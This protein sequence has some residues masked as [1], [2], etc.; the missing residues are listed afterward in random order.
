MI[1][2]IES[3]REQLSLFVRCRSSLAILSCN[4][5]FIFSGLFKNI[6]EVPSEVL[7]KL[8]EASK[9]GVYYIH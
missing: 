5:F 1:I 6:S 2:L 3:L 8:V 7:S 9:A 4:S